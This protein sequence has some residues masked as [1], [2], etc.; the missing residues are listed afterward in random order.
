ME[1]LKEEELEQEVIIPSI[2]TNI[3]QYD[4]IREECPNCKYYPLETQVFEY[5]RQIFCPRCSYARLEEM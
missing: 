2:S 5:E 3:D 1:Y 4:T